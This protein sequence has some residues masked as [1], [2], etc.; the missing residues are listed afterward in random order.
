VFSIRQY[1]LAMADAIAT[2]RGSMFTAQLSGR[3]ALMMAVAVTL[4]VVAYGIRAL[5]RFEIGEAA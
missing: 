1:T 5:Q 4:F 3:T 2:V